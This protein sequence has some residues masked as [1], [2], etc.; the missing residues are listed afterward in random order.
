M[1]WEYYYYKM[2]HVESAQHVAPRHFGNKQQRMYGVWKWKGS[3]PHSCCKVVELRN[4]HPGSPQNTH[5]L[6]KEISVTP[7]GYLFLY[8]S[9]LIS[10]TCPSLVLFY[11]LSHLSG[12]ARAVTPTML[13]VTPFSAAWLILPSVAFLNQSDNENEAAVA[14]GWLTG[15][16]WRTQTSYHLNI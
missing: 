6:E 8:S 14:H 7:F 15:G 13:C 3:S 4:E 16:R 2:M 10:S 5:S 11:F 1:S 12:P 9:S